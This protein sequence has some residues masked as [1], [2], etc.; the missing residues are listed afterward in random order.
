M[1]QKDEFKETLFFP[2]LRLNCFT[3]NV[4]SVPY[5]YDQPELGATD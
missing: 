2:L 1:T 5:S 4:L 3:F